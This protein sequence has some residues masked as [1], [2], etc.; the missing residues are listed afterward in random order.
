MKEDK[1]GSSK[2]AIVL[3]FVA[4]L[5]AALVS[6]FNINLWLAGT[7]WILIAILLAVYGTYMKKCDCKCCKNKDVSNQIG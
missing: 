4:L 1:N 3:S 7:Q 6:V 5:L 2:S